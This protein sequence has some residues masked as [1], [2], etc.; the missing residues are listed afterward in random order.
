MDRI[1]GVVGFDPEERA[2]MLVM[3]E[4]FEKFE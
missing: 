4:R 1:I 3:G 2:E